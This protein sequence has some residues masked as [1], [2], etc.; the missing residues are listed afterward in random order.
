M[1]V[2]LASPPTP[3]GSLTVPAAPRAVLA[4]L[5]ELRRWRDDLRSALNALDRRAQVATDADAFTGDL[6]LA[7]SL[8]ESISRRTDELIT[9]WDSGRVGDTEL[10]QLAQLMWGRLPDALGNPTAF[11]LSEATTLA[12]ALEARLAARLDADTIAGS[13]A[14][15]RLTPLRE[16]LARCHDLAATLERR[17]DDVDALATDL[18]KALATDAKTLGAEVARIADAAEVLER[19][20]IKELALRTSVSRDAALLTT[21][22]AELTMTAAEVQETAQRCREKI[23]DPPRLAVPVVTAL[24]PVPPVPDGPDQ[25]GTWT[26]ARIALDEYQGRLDRADAALAEAGR[27]YAAPLTERAEL[28]GLADAYR[29][30]AGAAGLAED[31][32]LDAQWGR[33]RDVLWQAPCDLAAS[34]ERLDEYSQAVQVAV[35]AVAATEPPVEAP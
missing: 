35:G 21:R 14:A 26:A 27:R 6:T 2:T 31:P 10:A 11:S 28:R 33:L 20:L 25:P 16:T 22:V 18:E 24:G 34:R 3:P 17:A 9:T 15:D 23:A 29:A 7:L 1:T 4:Y 8:A 5:D 32:A 30:K 19:D 13:G 12:A